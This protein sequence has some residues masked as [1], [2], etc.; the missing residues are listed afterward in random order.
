MPESIDR[1]YFP[2]HV[3]ARGYRGLPSD[4]APFQKDG[5]CRCH[6]WIVQSMYSNVTKVGRGGE[7]TEDTVVYQTMDPVL[8]LL[9]YH[10]SCSASY[11]YESTVGVT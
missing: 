6:L 9:L 3:E 7:V 8:H 4:G 11:L 2:G 10:F 5:I 1:P